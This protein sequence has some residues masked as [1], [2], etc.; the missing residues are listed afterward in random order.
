MKKIFAIFLS[1][2]LLVSVAVTVTACNDNDVVTDSLV[3]YN[4][5]DYIY[6]TKL[7]DF[8][9][10]YK[11][12][13]GNNIE[14]TYV[15]FDTNETMLTK[16]MQGDAQVDV[17]CPSE[18]AI[19]KLLE[20]DMLVSLNYFDEQKYRSGMNVNSELYVH[21]S[22]NIDRHIIE[23]IDEGFSDI[24]VKGNDVPQKMSDYL[25]PYMYGTLG[26]LYNKYAFNEMGIYDYET[27]NNANWVILF[28]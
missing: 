20:N 28:N 15:T 25:V 24:K 21:N 22:E 12:L 11:A 18:Y 9:D 4:W 14:I 2:V 17:I 10:Y 5:A 23:K 26:I 1:I 16:L 3:V 7:N 6:D 8:K 13:T 27:M 19:Q